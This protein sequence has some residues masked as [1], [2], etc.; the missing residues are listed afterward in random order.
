MLTEIQALICKTNF[1]MPRRTA[2]GTD[3]NR[4]NLLMAVLEKRA[5][6]RLSECDAYI[7]ITGGIKVVE[8]ALDLGIILA[9]ISSYRD[10][11][12]DDKTMVFGEVGLSGEVRGVSMAA[13]RVQEAVKLGFT[14]CIM[15]RIASK[16]S[17]EIKNASS[18]IELVE[19]ENV[20]E[21]LR[22][23]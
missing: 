4:V 15:P 17:W 14:R 18:E 21:A 11:A 23:L 6:L 10:I 19:V 5:G 8:P 9:I 16:T 12:I 20:R 1:G 7:N 3:Y 2:A 13:Q 22:L